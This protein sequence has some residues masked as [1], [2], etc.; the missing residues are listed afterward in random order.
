MRARRK[1]AGLKSRGGGRRPPG[2]SFTIGFLFLHFR[3]EGPIY[4]SPG[5]RPGRPTA[6]ETPSPERASQNAFSPTRV[7]ILDPVA[8]QKLTILFLETRGSVVRLLLLDVL[9]HAIYLARAHGETS[10]A[11]L[12]META[13]PSSPRLNPFGGTRFDLLHHLGQCTI[14]RKAEEGMNMVAGPSD[15]EGWLSHGC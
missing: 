10:V 14:L 12:P 15:F 13:Q 4:Q 2:V 9:H 8:L 7:R 5:Q 11:T 6:C 1:S 3:P